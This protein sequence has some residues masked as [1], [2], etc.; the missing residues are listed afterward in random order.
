MNLMGSPSAELIDPLSTPERA[1]VAS[2]G[3][4]RAAE[5]LGAVAA[6]VLLTE[7]SRIELTH[8]WSHSGTTDKHLDPD[9][10]QNLARALENWSGPIDAGSPLA[11]LLRDW[12]NRDAR[13]FLPFHCRIEGH[14]VTALFGFSESVV[15]HHAVPEVV[16]ERLNLVGI[17]AWSFREIARLRANLKVVSSRLASRKLVERAKGVL[18]T[19]RGLNE[20]QAYEHLRRTSRRRR[21][22]LTELAEEVLRTQARGSSLTPHLGQR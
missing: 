15:P 3:L 2:L 21:I 8:F 19:E 5:E 16:A 4:E 22:P 10:Q 1:L 9:K 12:I 18:Q 6:A 13:S 7:G 11:R 17:A 14:L 20:E